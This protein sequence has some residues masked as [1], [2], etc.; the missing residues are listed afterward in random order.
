MNPHDGVATHIVTTVLCS[1]CQTTQDPTVVVHLQEDGFHSG[2]YQC[3]K[4]KVSNQVIIKLEDFVS[5]GNKLKITTKT[6]C[7]SCEVQQQLE[8]V[9]VKNPA[10]KG[11]Y[12]CANCLTTNFLRMD[13]S[14]FDRLKDS[15]NQGV[16]QLK[17]GLKMKVNFWSTYPAWKLCLC[18]PCVVTAICF[19]YLECC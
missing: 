1:S 14:T 5:E 9:F 4:C 11:V 17:S 2:S 19:G 12:V 10:I 18:C 3:S 13:E 16:H 6:N 8:V 15:Q 7:A